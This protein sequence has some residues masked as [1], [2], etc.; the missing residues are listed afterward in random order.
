MRWGRVK[1]RDGGG[2]MLACL[3]EKLRGCLERA[4]RQCERFKFC[5]ALNCVYVLYQSR[6][7]EQ[8]ESGNTGL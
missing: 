4:V 5:R 1:E 6:G 3:D 7:Q 8:T 2:S